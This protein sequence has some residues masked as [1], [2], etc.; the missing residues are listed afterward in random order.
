MAIRRPSLAAAALLPVGG[1]AG[2]PGQSAYAAWLTLPGNAGKTVAQFVASLSAAGAVSPVDLAAAMAL[3]DG[4]LIDEGASPISGLMTSDLTRRQ[5]AASLAGAAAGTIGAALVGSLTVAQFKAAGVVGEVAARTAQDRMRERVSITDMLCADSTPVV[6]N[7]V[8]QDHTAALA[9]AFTRAPVV[10]VPPGSGAIYLSG[11]TIPSG[12]TLAGADGGPFTIRPLDGTGDVLTMQT[13]S[14]IIR[15]TFD[16]LDGATKR[17]GGAYITL[18]AGTS[19]QLVEQPKFLRGYKCIVSSASTVRMLSPLMYLGAAGGIGIEILAGLAVYIDNPQAYHDTVGSVLANIRLASCGDVDIG[20][21][22][23][24]NA[25]HQ[26][27]VNPGAGQEV[28]SLKIL[29]TYLD[30]GTNGLTVQT[31]G[32]HVQRSEM[33]GSWTS[34]HTGYGAMLDDTGGGGIDGFDIGDH[35][36]YGNGGKGVYFKGTTNC[37]FGN[38]SRAAGNANDAGFVATNGAAKFKLGEGGLRLGPKGGFGANAYG[39][40]IDGTCTGYAVDPATDDQG[41]TN[42]SVY[43]GTPLE[44]VSTRGYRTRTRG[45][46]NVTTNASGIVSVAHGLSIAPQAWAGTPRT[47]AGATNSPWSASPYGTPDGTNMGFL[48]LDKTGAPVASSTAFNLY[49][50]AI[51]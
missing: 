27:L 7:G 19:L 26:I 8:A 24:C 23:L 40:Y 48:I 29:R 51:A 34:G 35:E 17:T 41:N 36:A 37:T 18:P 6:L 31:A 21:G 39:T 9:R 32:G 46:V 30:S 16:S 38:Q 28:D 22:N 45:Y 33:F 1:P 20:R 42:L 3:A 47:P 25:I 13:E 49:Y 12:C 14:R 5:I 15:P 4:T 11:A 50:D 10:T 2:L 44:R 43:G